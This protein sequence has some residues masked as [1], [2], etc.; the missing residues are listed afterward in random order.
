MAAMIDPGAEKYIP[1]K[2]YIPRKISVTVSGSGCLSRRTA[3]IIFSIIFL[4]RSNIFG[5]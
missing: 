5:I 1:C 3:V 2:N 4:T